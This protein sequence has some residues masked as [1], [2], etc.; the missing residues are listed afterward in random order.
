MNQETHTIF[1]TFT[2][3]SP[4]E[5]VFEA[6][7]E[8]RHLIHWWPQKC[9]GFP[10]IGSTYNFFFTPEYNWYGV[11]SKI[12]NP[13]SFYI[14]MTEA[15]ADWNPTTFGFE[16]EAEETQKTRVNFSHSHWPNC[17]DHFKI[18]S[19]CWAI[20]LKGLKEYL[21]EGKIIPFEKR[22]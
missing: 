6:V 7:S 4:I 11:V 13:T 19:Y 12:S 21:E 22:A 15:D 9:D 18:A 20:L 16:L 14:K 10:E 8:P 5:K 1:H 2:I 17:N 3:L